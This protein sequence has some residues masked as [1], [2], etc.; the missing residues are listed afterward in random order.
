MGFRTDSL[1][2]GSLT[3]AACDGCGSHV[4][5]AYERVFADTGDRINGCPACVSPFVKEA[6]L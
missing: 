4:S 5:L 6:A 2:E 3:M 1:K